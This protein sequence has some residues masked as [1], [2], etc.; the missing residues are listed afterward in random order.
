[1]TQS[2]FLCKA[3]F[4][5]FSTQTYRGENSRWTITLLFLLGK[6]LLKKNTALTS[7]KTTLMSSI[8]FLN[9]L[10]TATDSMAQLIRNI[11]LKPQREFTCHVG[12]CS[13]VNKSLFLFIITPQFSVLKGA[14]II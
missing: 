11:F 10:S 8:N 5:P 2:I 7:N 14:D 9:R 3:S 6:V 12:N 4:S 1:M 13:L